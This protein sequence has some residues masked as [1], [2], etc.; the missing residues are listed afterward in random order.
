MKKYV[1]SDR[2]RDQGAF[3]RLPNHDQVVQK[4]SNFSLLR[5]IKYNKIKIELGNKK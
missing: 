4:D 1:P 3:S 5:I 2:E